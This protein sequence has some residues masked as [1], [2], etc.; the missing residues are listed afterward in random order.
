M[1]CG[2]C[3][4][5]Q[6]KRHACGLPPRIILEPHSIWVGKGNYKKLLHFLAGLIIW[7][8][9]KILDWKT[10]N[11][12]QASSTT[13]ESPTI[14]TEKGNPIRTRTIPRTRTISISPIYK[15]IR[16]QYCLPQ[17]SGFDRLNLHWSNRTVSNHIQQRQQIYFGG[18]PLLS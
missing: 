11:H 16:H 1:F 10:S 6:I 7:S 12:T 4:W 18:L 8:C 9:A 5:V 3:V 14:H 13:S 2:E 17:D 15:V